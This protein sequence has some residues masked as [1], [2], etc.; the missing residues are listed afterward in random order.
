MLGT[1]IFGL[2][3]SMILEWEIF[4]WGALVAAVGAVVLG[5]AYPAY[6]FF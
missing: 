2:G 1:L 6:R 3:L 4:A 5:A